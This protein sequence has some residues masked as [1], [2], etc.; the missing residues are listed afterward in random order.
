LIGTEVKFE[1]FDDL[2]EKVYLVDNV[3]VNSPAFKAGLGSGR[4][5]Q[6]PTVSIDRLGLDFVIA[7]GAKSLFE[8]TEELT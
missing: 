3:Q 8:T 6:D 2:H 5:A 7:S 1:R 4:M